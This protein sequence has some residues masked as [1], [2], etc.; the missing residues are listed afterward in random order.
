[1]EDFR[2]KKERLRKLA[3]MA[4][5]GESGLLQRFESIL[6]EKDELERRVER[7]TERLLDSLKEGLLEEAQ[8][9]DVPGQEKEFQLII[10]LPEL[11]VEPLKRLADSLVAEMDLGAVLLGSRGEKS[12]S[13]ICK[14][15]AG[16]SPATGELNAGEVISE[17]ARIIGGGGG[18]GKEFA[19]G[20]G[21]DGEKLEEALR[22]GERFI[23]EILTEKE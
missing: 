4:G 8:G 2:E 12:A 19:Q 7:L 11:E 5:A 15:A 9:I 21:P 20:G 1:M 3:R 16:D 13:L 17:T 14:L 22:E 23:R 10:G 18:G 6:E